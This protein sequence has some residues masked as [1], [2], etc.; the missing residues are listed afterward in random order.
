MEQQQEQEQEQMAQQRNRYG[1]VLGQARQAMEDIRVMPR[2]GRQPDKWLA[3]ESIS[4]KSLKQ[5]KNTVLGAAQ[6][7]SRRVDAALLAI[8]L[9]GDSVRA[10]QQARYKYAYLKNLRSELDAHQD[11]LLESRRGVREAKRAR[12]ETAV[13]RPFEVQLLEEDVGELSEEEQDLR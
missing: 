11:E 7:T 12:R 6:L 10:E 13:N 5:M 8:S 1:E 9:L 2:G 3:P 4:V